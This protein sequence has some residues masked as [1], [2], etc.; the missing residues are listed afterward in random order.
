MNQ[1]KETKASLTK[2]FDFK[3]FKEALSFINQVG[4]LAENQN[5]HPDIKLH[6]YNKVELTLSTHSEG[7]VTNKDH[8]LAQSIDNL[9][10]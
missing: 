4:E 10:Q 5:H 6:S 9:L 2:E 7:K 8:Q 3:D 1:W